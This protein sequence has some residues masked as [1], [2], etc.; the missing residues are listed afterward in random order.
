MGYLRSRTYGGGQVQV[1]QQDGAYTAFTRYLIQY[2]SDGLKIA[3][4]MDVP[5]G[6]GPFPVVIAIHGY[7]Y[8]S[9]YNTLDYTTPYAD[10]MAMAGFLVIHPN[11]RNYAPSSNGDDLF[12]VGMAI[13][14]LNLVS[15]VKS[16]G[17]QAGALQ[18]ADPARIGMWGHGVGGG[19]AL[20]VATVSPDI[21]AVVL[22][23][24]LSG[25]EQRNLSTLSAWPNN[26]SSNKERSVPAGELP[27]ISPM[28]FYQYMQAAV[29]IN[30]GL[31]DQIIPVQW[32]QDTC[33]QLQEMG[34]TVEC[35]YYPGEYNTFTSNED[36]TFTRQS[37]LFLEK[38]LRGQ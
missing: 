19:V 18:L 31:S 16:T 12:H 25:D 27:S 13:D 11:L 23:S 15:I 26:S 3:G 30:Q 35:K 22:Y 9:V 36:R 7:V 5:N 10:A 14:V 20:R 1:L 24:S 37:I 34:K 6:T 33:T 38:Y 8:P 21:K 28:Y 32:A 17:G 4:F 2:P 29:S